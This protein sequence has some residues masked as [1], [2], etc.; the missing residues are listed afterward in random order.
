MNK[1]ITEEIKARKAIND[2]I[3]EKSKEAAA[4]A[5]AENEVRF[6]QLHEERKQAI[7]NIEAETARI[8]EAE[9]QRGRAAA[10]QRK[11]MSDEEWV[12]NMPEHHLAGYLGVEDDVEE[13]DDEGEDKNEDKEDNG[14]DGGSDGGDDDGDDLL[15]VKDEDMYNDE[16]AAADAEN[17]QEADGDDDNNGADEEPEE[18]GGE[19]AEQAMA[20]SLAQA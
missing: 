11:G 8:N 1:K 4:A 15:G 7:A 18:D 9:R 12:A 2:D 6:R 20:Q 17:N 14:E 16:D 19:A 5:A 10:D 13:A 3:L